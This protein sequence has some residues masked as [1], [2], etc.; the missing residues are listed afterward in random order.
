MHI[1][2]EREAKPL[3][4]MVGKISPHPAPLKFRDSKPVD[5]DVVIFPSNFTFSALPSN[6]YSNLIYNSSLLLPNLL[7]EISSFSGDPGLLNEV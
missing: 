6:E 7:L 5:D 3:L 1:D 2:R 4:P